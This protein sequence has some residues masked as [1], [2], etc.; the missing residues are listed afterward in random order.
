MEN[1]YVMRYLETCFKTNSSLL[2]LA[3][4]QA[5]GLNVFG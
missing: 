2:M 3:K 4:V 5:L 1:P